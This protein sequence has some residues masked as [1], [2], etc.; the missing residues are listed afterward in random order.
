MD[1]Y[2]S[3]L[4]KVW[5]ESA[6]PWNKN[7]VLQNVTFPTNL[8]FDNEMIASINNSSTNNL[9]ISFAN[10]VP[11]MDIIDFF[12]KKSYA[13]TNQFKKAVLVLC[14]GD[15]KK[16]ENC[17]KYDFSF[18]CNVYESLKYLNSQKDRMIYNFIQSHPQ[19]EE[20][21]YRLKKIKK[22]QDI[23]SVQAIIPNEIS[24][25]I[26]NFVQSIVL[27]ESKYA[28]NDI[29]LDGFL[30]D[31]YNEVYGN[32][33]ITLILLNESQ[34][35]NICQLSYAIDKCATKHISKPVYCL[36]PFHTNDNL[37]FKIIKMILCLGVLNNDGKKI[38]LDVIKTINSINFLIKSSKKN[39]NFCN[40]FYT[41]LKNLE[42]VD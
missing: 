37:H 16:N 3:T 10:D 14:F 6:I 36:K 5:E 1:I 12:T 32:S 8:F 41:Y 17:L 33:D 24:A 18:C 35:I 34:K 42:N 20:N 19:Y 13:K 27:N 9:T 15:F 40:I 30:Y 39:V 7:L 2:L 4:I 29:L 11:V 28:E 31:A 23:N 25:E 26:N 38:S 22:K 21:E